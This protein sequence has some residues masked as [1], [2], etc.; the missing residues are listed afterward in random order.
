MLHSAP[1]FMCWT[2]CSTKNYFRRNFFF[3]LAVQNSTKV[4]K[5]GFLRTFPVSL[6]NFA[7]ALSWPL[8]SGMTREKVM[9]D[10]EM[11]WPKDPSFLRRMVETT[12]NNTLRWPKFTRKGNVG[13]GRFNSFATI[14]ILFDLILNT[15]QEIWIL[16]TKWQ[17]CPAKDAILNNQRGLWIL[18]ECSDRRKPNH[19]YSR[20]MVGDSCLEKIINLDDTNLQ[21]IWS[22]WNLLIPE[23][24]EVAVK[25]HVSHSSWGAEEWMQCSDLVYPKLK[26]HKEVISKETQW[27]VSYK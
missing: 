5:F 6:I 10:K 3:P 7:S 20:D 14:S 2:I 8:P 22:S 23:G 27:S 26:Q 16:T 13:F 15:C 18:C 1:N 24:K 4:S 19:R 25:T 21:I 11:A 17:R 12:E 9:A